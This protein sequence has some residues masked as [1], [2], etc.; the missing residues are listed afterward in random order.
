M[1]RQIC[2]AIGAER[3]LRFVYDGYER[4]VEPHLY[5]INSA[6]HEALSAWLVEGWSA[7]SPEAGWRNYLVADMHDIQVL[8]RPFTGPRPGFNPGDRS[9]RQIYCSLT[10]AGATAPEPPG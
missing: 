7:T 5:G 4:I 8:A 9:F 1:N 3:L 10:A 6:N 2:D